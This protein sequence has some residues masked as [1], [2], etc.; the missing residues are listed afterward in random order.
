M[1]II[2]SRFQHLGNYSVLTI[3]Y[4]KPQLSISSTQFPSFDIS[5]HHDIPPNIAA[6]HALSRVAKPLH[7]SVYFNTA[8]HTPPLQR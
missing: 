1:P 8:R 4:P 7:L 2:D 3:T 5:A 6:S